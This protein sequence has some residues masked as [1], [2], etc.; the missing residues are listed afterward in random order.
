MN[1]GFITVTNELNDLPS[2]QIGF[3]GE[4]RFE[5]Y[6]VRQNME[7]DPDN[8]V[9]MQTNTLTNTTDK[10]ITVNRLSSVYAEGIAKGFYEKDS[11][12]M[13]RRKIGFLCRQLVDRKVLPDCFNRR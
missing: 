4:C 8:G 9:I 3:T 6:T 12:G 13:P 10:D 2:C 1:T 11:R 7:K 5:G